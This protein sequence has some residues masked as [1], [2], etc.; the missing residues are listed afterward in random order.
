MWSLAD[1]KDQLK[2]L[3]DRTVAGRTGN[4][5]ISHLA[6]NSPIP[7]GP[8][9]I[10]DMSNNVQRPSLGILHDLLL[11]TSCNGWRPQVPLRTALMKYIA[12]QSDD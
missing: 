7:N 6:V 4:F 10:E 3:Y 2:M 11:D 8:I 1:T 5:D 9:A 12:L